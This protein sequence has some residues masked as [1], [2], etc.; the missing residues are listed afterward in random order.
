MAVERGQIPKYLYRYRPCNDFTFEEL[1]EGYMWYS[2]VD[3]YNDPFEG[4]L[5]FDTDC[6]ID[7]LYNYL[8]KADHQRKLTKTKAIELAKHYHARPQELQERFSQV[9]E[10][11]RN[12]IGICSLTTKP[13]NLLMWSHYS[14]GH[15]GICIK[16]STVKLIEPGVAPVIVEY[17][18][19]Y[20]TF[21]YIREWEDKLKLASE[22]FQ[23]KSPDWAYEEE[24]RLVTLDRIGK[25]GLKRQAM[26][27]VIL[28]ARIS[29]EN[30]ERIEHSLSNNIYQ[31]PII[32][33]AKLMDT[34]FGIEIV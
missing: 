27:E 13:D 19:D 8:I 34:T 25:I 7:E 31:K 2:N 11:T 12:R 15:T 3:A 14:S 32:R 20:P 17:T 29:K 24:H 6:K 1:S 9:R 10:F 30:T 21:N 28:G 26:L 33:K 4:I 22:S 16:Y 5:K 18:N 23:K